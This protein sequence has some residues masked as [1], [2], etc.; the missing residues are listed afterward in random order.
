M[1]QPRP[2]ESPC[3]RC[4]AQSNGSSFHHSSFSFHHSYFPFILSFLSLPRLSHAAFQA[5]PNGRPLC[6]WP[7]SRSPRVIFKHHPTTILRVTSTTPAALKATRLLRVDCVACPHWPRTVAPRSEWA[8]DDPCYCTDHAPAVISSF[9]FTT[10][11]LF[12]S[13]TTFLPLCSL[14]LDYHSPSCH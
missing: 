2:R 7:P 13:S 4:S 9:S 5:S 8:T 11:P 10:F 3:L 12:P 6:C 14:C 1:R